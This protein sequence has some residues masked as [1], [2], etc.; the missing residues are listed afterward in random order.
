METLPD[1]LLYGRSGCHLC[2]VAEET[3][4][5]LAKSLQFNL[6]KVLIDGD[7]DLE[8][9]YGEQI[10]VVTINGKV[11]DFFRVDPERFTAAIKREPHQHQ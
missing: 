10:P 4:H 7:P 8:Y 5:E 6:T 1:V 3:L 9:K 11:H 2:D